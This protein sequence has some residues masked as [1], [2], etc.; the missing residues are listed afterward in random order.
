MPFGLTN[1]PSTFNKMMDWLFR[2]NCAYIGVFFDD[3][4]HSKKLDEHKDHLK[5]NF[6][7]L[8]DHMLYI[9]AKKSE[10]F[11]QKVSYLGH[12]ISKEGIQTYSQKLKV[13]K[14]WPILKTLHNLRS[15]LYMCY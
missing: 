3:I 9:N 5:G 11:L 15:F 14:E 2:K 12:I 6:E 7:E 4:I 13:I 10:L 8:G 1:A